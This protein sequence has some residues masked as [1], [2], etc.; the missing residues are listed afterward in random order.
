[1]KTKEN[2]LFTFDE[3]PVSVQQKVVKELQHINVDYVWWNPVYRRFARIARRFGLRVTLENTYFSGVY[4][5]HYGFSYAAPIDPDKLIECVGNSEWK[6]VAPDLAFDFSELT[7]A[8]T[9]VY[10]LNTR[11]AIELMP[12]VRTTNRGANIEMDCHCIHNMPGEKDIPV[13]VDH[14][15][16]QTVAF[17]EDVCT[18]LNQTLL[19]GVQK[20]YNFRTSEKAIIKTIKSLQYKFSKTGELAN[21]D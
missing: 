20:E 8:V 14:A 15:I 18:K 6:E 21:P 13:N 12:F 5:Q 11:K 2:K 10:K 7:P 17:I 16:T 19:L 4:A 1:M 9:R 3:L